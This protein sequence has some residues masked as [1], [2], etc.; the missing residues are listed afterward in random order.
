MLVYLMKQHGVKKVIASPGTTNVTFVA[1]IQNDP[2]F[3][4]Y[5]AAD[6]R[7]AAYM[8]C[9]LAAES[10]EPV[11]LSCTGATA[12]RNYVPGLTEAYYRKLPVLAITSTQ[13]TGRIGQLCA[14]VID[15]SQVQNDIA[16]KSVTIPLIGSEEDEWDCNIKLNDALLALSHHGGGPVHLNLMT[17]YSNDFSV[18]PLP[19]FRIINRIGLNDAFPALPTGKIGI[20]VGAHL[21]WSQELTEAVDEFC[22]KYD[23]VVFKDHTSNFNGEYGVEYSLVAAQNY[24][25]STRQMD[26]LIDMGEMSGAYMNLQP[27]SVWR[28]NP[29]GEI[30]D[31]WK[32]LTKVF[33]MEEINFFKH[34]N[35]LR[36]ETTKTT[37]YA[38]CSAEYADLLRRLPELPFSNDW[39]ASVTAGR[40]PEGS[41][42]HLG[43]LNTLRSWNFF[44]VPKTVDCFCNTGGFGIDGLMSTC[45][46]ASLANPDRLHFLVLG[47]LAFF[48]DLNSIANH[49]VGKNLRILLVNNGC[50]TEFKN[51][52]HFAAQ[53]GDMANEYMAAMGHYGNKSPQLV[54]HYATDLGFEYLTASSKEEYLAVLDQFLTPTLTDRPMLLEIFTDYRDESDALQNLNTMEIS[55]K[56]K[57]KQVVKNL[58]GADTAHKLKKLIKG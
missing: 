22:A 23:A 43:I 54:K 19:E 1:S 27:K 24:S 41:A 13:H 15:R 9:G 5:S 38:E 37:Y 4:I 25:Y 8:A 12:S 28:V 56:E 42:L 40:I 6:E 48:Y 7:S 30:R 3:E 18:N 2:Y 45:V 33:E 44:D 31:R 17:Q 16:V 11:A 36:S 58:I 46:G 14:Q 34:Y 39:I 50:G 10:H 47:D 51:Y 21:T 52:N 53:F 29:D 20:F 55:T 26:L 57:T 35:A 49:N 32:K